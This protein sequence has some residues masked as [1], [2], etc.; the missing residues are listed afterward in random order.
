M[1]ASEMWHNYVNGHYA[2]MGYRMF[3]VLYRQNVNEEAGWEEIAGTFDYADKNTDGFLSHDEFV[4]LA[5]EY[6]AGQGGEG[7]E[8]EHDHDWTH[9][10]NE[11]AEYHDDG[12]PFMSYEGF[13]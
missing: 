10:W 8:D 1:D 12:M 7:G 6:E 2:G 4:N 3:N 9:Y 13:S 5:E 11:Y